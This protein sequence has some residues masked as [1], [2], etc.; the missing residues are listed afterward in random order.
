M[1]LLID[2]VVSTHLLNNVFCNNNILFLTDPGL[3][4]RITWLQMQQER[5]QEVL[6]TKSESDC[7]Y[8]MH[9]VLMFMILIDSSKRS[10][11]YRED[12]F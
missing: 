6:E 9:E 5:M 1:R 8:K 11:F 7:I 3:K 4:S 10:R 12:G 2:S